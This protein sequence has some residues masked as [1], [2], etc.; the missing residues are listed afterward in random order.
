MA[1]RPSSPPAAIA[2]EPKRPCRDG[3]LIAAL[4]FPPQEELD[5][6]QASCDADATTL[7]EGTRHGRHFTPALRP[8]HFR[9]WAAQ[10]ARPVRAYGRGGGARARRP[11]PPA[12]RFRGVGRDQCE[13][14][15]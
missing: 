8:D 4:P 9:P 15:R 5:P 11:P 14:P 12:G 6:P 10:P 1:A 3:R 7:C 2:A 13:E